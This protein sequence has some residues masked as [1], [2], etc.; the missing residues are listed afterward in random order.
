MEELI[1]KDFVEHKMYLLANDRGLSCEL[2]D[3][4]C[5]NDREKGFMSLIRQDV[6]PG[7][8]VCDIGANIGLV[9]LIMNKLV[10]KSGRVY[11]IEPSAVNNVVLC[12]NVDLNGYASRTIVEKFGVSDA[13]GDIIFYNSDKSNL[14]SCIL[15]KNSSGNTSLISV[16][17]IDS[18]FNQ[19][20]DIPV[21]YKMDVEGYEAK[22]LLGMRE[23]LKRS[24]PKTKILIEVHPQYYSED[25]NMAFSLREILSIGMHFRYLISA[26][27]A[28]PDLFKEKGYKP[29]KTV[30]TFGWSR[31][32]YDNIPSEDAIYFSAYPHNQNCG[33]KGISPKI[34][35]AIM[36][37]KD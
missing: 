1:L 4:R 34:V 13:D 9:T 37:E 8:I 23:T 25:L 2:A 32:I 31:G 21:F 18:Y 10:G 30:N 17:S 19:I 20:R 11:A 6:K 12:K 26:G 15:T 22:I 36:L 33:R 16:R 14:G 7:D 3:T 28:Q 29:F 35:R 27:V 5:Y 24:P